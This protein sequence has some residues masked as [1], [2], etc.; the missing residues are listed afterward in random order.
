MKIFKNLREGL[1]Q[2]ACKYVCIIKRTRKMLRNVS[3]RGA[4][5]T[6][7]I[8][9][10][11][12]LLRVINFKQLTLESFMYHVM[13]IGGNDPGVVQFARIF[14]PG[15]ILWTSVRR[16]GLSSGTS[17]IQSDGKCMNSGQIGLFN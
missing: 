10:A 2:F 4:A 6:N 16:T 9:T 5:N 1:L 3:F 13:F 11:R 12:G 17:A 14:A 8:A 15:A 7:A